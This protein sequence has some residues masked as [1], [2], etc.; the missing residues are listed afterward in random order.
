MY[1]EYFD[2]LSNE[3]KAAA[4][5]LDFSQMFICSSDLTSPLLLSPI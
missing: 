5:Y 1:E 3:V 2:C 4:Y